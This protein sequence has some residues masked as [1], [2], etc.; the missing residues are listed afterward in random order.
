MKIGKIYLY[1]DDYV[2]VVKKFRDR[3]IDRVSAYYVIL[4]DGTIDVIPSS[5]LK[6]IKQTS[7]N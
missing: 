4:S 1:H 2:L 6:T 3:Q 5:L 7:S